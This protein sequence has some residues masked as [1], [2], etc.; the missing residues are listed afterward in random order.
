MLAIWKKS[1]NREAISDNIIETNEATTN[2][3]SS[4]ANIAF[5][6][7][8]VRKDFHTTSLN[9]V[10]NN[11]STNETPLSIKNND[12]EKNVVSSEKTTPQ[13]SVIEGII[14]PINETDLE[15]SSVEK[16]SEEIIEDNNFIE[17]ENGE[18]QNEKDS[19]QDNW[20]KCLDDL[21]NKNIML[22]LLL[23]MI[24]FNIV[25]NQKINLRIPCQLYYNIIDNAKS[26]L[27]ELLKIKSKSNIEII[28]SLENPQNIN[29]NID[30]TDVSQIKRL[31]MYDNENIHYLQEALHLHVNY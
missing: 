29:E 30:M 5:R 27:T 4:V 11:I 22:Q 14:P 8:T 31:I 2:T 23:K 9:G 26:E 15:T 21:S 20:I 19:L 3:N 24:P 7:P 10:Y 12:E 16:D 28:L 13:N 25:N 6:R 17:N 18:N 1:G